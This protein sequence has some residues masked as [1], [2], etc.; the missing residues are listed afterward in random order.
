MVFVALSSTYREG[1]S[2]KICCHQKKRQ[3]SALGILRK[4]QELCPSYTLPVDLVWSH[5]NHVLERGG[6]ADQQPE[7]SQHGKGIA[8][9][10]SH[11]LLHDKVRS[12]THSFL[13]KR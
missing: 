12:N 3:T 2:D 4:E 9:G 7:S 8:G 11:L 5:Q 1:P 10:N 6:C 13:M